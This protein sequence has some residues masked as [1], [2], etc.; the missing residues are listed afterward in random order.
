M[1]QDPFIWEG[2]LDDDCIA[3]GY[4]LI[5][6]AEWMDED[7]WWWAV[8]DMNNHEK[9]IDCSNEYEERYTSGEQAR[10][11]AEEVALRYLERK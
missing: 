6:R 9:T 1:R 4:G 2:D 11:A 10:R 3:K 5:L 7:Y 8:Y